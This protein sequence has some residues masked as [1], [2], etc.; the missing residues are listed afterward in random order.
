[1]KKKMHVYYDPEGDFLEVRFG[2]PT[3]CY[4]E[5]ID[6]DIFEKRDEK[7]NELKGYAIFNVQKH[8]TIND[9]EV[10]MPLLS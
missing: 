6:K 5:E 8:M 4:Y 2:N 7:T 9:L 10:E 3:L 1:M